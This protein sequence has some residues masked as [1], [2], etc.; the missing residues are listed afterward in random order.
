VSRKGPHRRDPY[1]H[2][3][4]AGM[5]DSPT[6]ESFCGHNPDPRLPV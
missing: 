6:V 2:N 5:G 4:D 1:W 3:Q